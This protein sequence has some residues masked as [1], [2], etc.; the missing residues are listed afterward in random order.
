MSQQSLARTVSAYSIAAS[1]LLSPGTLHVLLKPAHCRR[2]LPDSLK[3]ETQQ[4]SVPLKCSWLPAFVSQKIVSTPALN[5]E[6]LTQFVSKVVGSI[7]Q[8]DSSTL[9]QS[10]CNISVKPKPIFLFNIIN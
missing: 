5:W 7:G 4:P 10:S 6:M 2:V 3:T 8:N 9:D 1:Q